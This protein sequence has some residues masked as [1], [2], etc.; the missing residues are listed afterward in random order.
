[1]RISFLAMTLAVTASTANAQEEVDFTVGALKWR[2]ESG[3]S[4]DASKRLVKVE[5]KGSVVTF[6]TANGVTVSGSAAL[7]VD[8][9]SG[10]SLKCQMN[11]NFCGPADKKVRISYDRKIDIPDW[12][13][14]VSVQEKDGEPSTPPPFKAKWMRFLSPGCLLGNSI[15]TTLSEAEVKALRKRCGEWN[16]NC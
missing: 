4:A 7:I 16:V 3:C 12:K 13:C 1:M 15:W 5:Q 6:T 8:K 10:P 14:V 2:C 9:Q 11:P